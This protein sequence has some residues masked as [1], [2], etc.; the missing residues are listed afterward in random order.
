MSQR[1]IHDPL[2]DR[3]A[4]VGAGLDATLINGEAHHGCAVLLAEGQDPLQHL[5][6][7]VHRVDD[8][9]AVIDPQAPL[10]GVGVGGIQLQRQAHHALQGLDHLLHDGRLVHTGSAHID[11]QHLCAGLGLADGLLEDVVHISLAEGLL[12]PL[13]AGGVDALS[14]HGDAVHRDEIHRRAEHRG[15][16]VGSPARP[17]V[18]E[19]AVQQPDEIGGGAAAAARREELQLPVGLHLHGKELGGDVVAAAVGPGQAR[20]GLDEDREIAGQGL[21][22]TLRHREDLLRAEGAVDAHGICA[23]APGRDGEALDGAAGK[24]APACLKAH[25]GEDGQRAVLFRGQQGG[26][27]LVEVGEGLE[28]DEVGPGSRTGP[29]DAAILGHGVLKG[30]RAVG[31]QQLAQRADVQ[32][33]QRA[34]GGAGPLAVGDARR[35]DLFQRVLAARQL[36][37]RRAE[38]VGVDDAASGGGVAAVDALDELRVGDV[39]LLGPC[40]Q[41]QARCLQHG[42]HTAVQKDGVGLGKQFIRLHRSC[43]SF[44]IRTACSARSGR[45][46]RDVLSPGGRSAPAERS[47]SCGAS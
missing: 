36:V 14:H 38:G 24:G 31:F 29:D 2:C 15:H 21:G 10:E 6:L 35:N 42:A 11:V 5:R 7:A 22:Q 8:G 32:R 20:V 26:L 30:Q 39:Q 4:G 16:G 28:E 18:G 12:E 33:R 41:L 25:A 23:E 47:R 46:R 43:P 40:P 9:L 34:V 37:G 44:C 27:Q 13:F 19:D 3:K 17:A 45:T 1:G